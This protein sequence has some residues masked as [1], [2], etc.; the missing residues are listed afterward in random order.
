M[1]A[2]VGVLDGSECYCNAV[3]RDVN[4]VA[5]TPTSLSYQ[6][7]D[8]TNSVNV[9]P[10]TA[11]TGTLAS[12][13]SITITSTQNAMNPA[14]KLRERRQVLLK[15]GVPGGTFRYDRASYVL[16]RAVGTP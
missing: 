11:Y 16:M 9:V 6:I 5:Y 4:G 2:D 13:L 8:L 7:D 14:S 3:F 10:M 1:G 15:I 12:T